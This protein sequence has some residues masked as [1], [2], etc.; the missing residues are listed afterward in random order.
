MK[1]RPFQQV[2]PAGAVRP[3][4][5]ATGEIPSIV[6]LGFSPD[7]RQVVFS[8]TAKEADETWYMAEFSEVDL[9]Q[10]PSDVY[11]LDLST[12]RSELPDARSRR[13]AVRR[14]LG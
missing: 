8:G 6:C 11:V 13:P 4:S 3:Y 12:G 2:R 7:G 5:P 9:K 1:M 10:L 14:R